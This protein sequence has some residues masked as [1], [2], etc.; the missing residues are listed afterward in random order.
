MSAKKVSDQQRI[1][2]LTEQLREMET[3]WKRALADYQNAQKR[4]QQQQQFLA[5]MACVQLVKRLLPALDHLELAAAHL[6]DSG[7]QMVVNQFQDALAAEGIESIRAAGEEFDPNRMECVDQVPGT[8]NMVIAEVAR[9]YQ[10]G[11]H[12]IRPAKVRVGSGAK[13]EDSKE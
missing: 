9:G 6:E 4:Q 10:T 1:R 2:E 13:K 12:I 5:Q 11:D 3:N 7:L 8:E